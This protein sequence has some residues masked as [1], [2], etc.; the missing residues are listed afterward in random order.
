MLNTENSLD[1]ASAMSIRGWEATRKPLADLYSVL[2]IGFKKIF[3]Q[4]FVDSGIIRPFRDR[5]KNLKPTKQH[6]YPTEPLS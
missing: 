2:K 3:G 4:Y 1:I 5:Y 6:Q